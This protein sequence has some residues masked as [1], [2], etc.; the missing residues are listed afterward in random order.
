MLSHI[1]AGLREGWNSIDK[2][3]LSAVMSTAAH[4]EHHG[5]GVLEAVVPALARAGKEFSRGYKR[6]QG[7]PPMSAKEM[8]AEVDKAGTQ[9]A[10]RT[11]SF[12]Q[13]IRPLS[14]A[15]RDAY[16]NRKM[17]GATGPSTVRRRNETAPSATS[18]KS[19]K[20]SL[21]LFTSFPDL[22]SPQPRRAEA[23]GDTS[24][25]GTAKFQRQPDVQME[26]GTPTSRPQTIPDLRHH[27][28]LWTPDSPRR[29]SPLTDAESLNE[30][31]SPSNDQ[32]W[33][34]A[35]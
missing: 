31:R 17:G 11:A 19:P 29:D 2:G 32:A 3:N 23:H 9:A 35:R 33:S 1:K 21:T 20:P 4:A 30:R 10:A 12:V 5:L 15:I 16:Q 28:V 6:T 14:T 22:Q 8:S 24:P 34:A 7:T 27:E 18:P 25:L 13:T 26:P